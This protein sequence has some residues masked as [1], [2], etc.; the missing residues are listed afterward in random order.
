VILG[1]TLTHSDTS[2]PVYDKYTGAEFCHVALAD[3]DM[4]EKA[5]ALAAGPGRD[6]IRALLPYQRQQIL[7]N[8]AVQA[9]ERHE[10]FAFYVTLKAGKPITDA[11]G[12]VDRFIATFQIAAEEATRIED[13]KKFGMWAPT[14]RLFHH[15]GRPPLF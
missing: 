12:E 1:G 3:A 8:V 13:V 14:T 11:R 4:I 6:R 2:L 5:N 7:H 9:K 15:C 10:E